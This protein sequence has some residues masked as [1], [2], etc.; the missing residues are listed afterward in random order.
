LDRRLT[1]I[2]A[3]D[4]VGYS[5]LMGE[6][7]TGTLAALRRF[8]T[9]LLARSLNS[10]SGNLIKSMGDG[11]LLGFASAADAAACALYLQH[12]LK[13]HETLKLRIGVHIG[14]VTFEEDDVYGDGINIAARL[15]EMV[16]P[17]A[18]L[19]SH[20]TMRLLDGVAGSDFAD[21]GRHRLKNIEKDMTIHVWPAKLSAELTPKAE[22][23]K[24]HKPRLFAPPFGFR[25]GADEELLA[26][27]ITGTFATQMGRMTGIELVMDAAEANYRLDGAVQAAGK[28]RRLIAHVIY[29]AEE[30]RLASEQYDVS[31]EDAFAIAEECAS[32]LYNDVRV[33][34]NHHDGYLASRKDLD[35]MTVEELLT[36][37][38]Y[39]TL[40]TDAKSWHDIRPL[41]D[42]VLAAE[43]DN[44][45]ALG[46]WSHSILADHLY[47]IKKT[48]EALQAEAWAKLDRA[49]H[50]NRLSAYV[51]LV[52]SNLT[53][54]FKNDVDEALYAAERSIEINPKFAFGYAAW[55]DALVAA[56]HYREGIEKVQLAFDM[57]PQGGYIHLRYHGL[58][59]GWFGLGDYAEAAKQMQNADRTVPNVPLFVLSSISSLWHSGDTDKARALSSELIAACPNIQLRDLHL[60]YWHDEEVAARYISGMLNA[61]I[62]E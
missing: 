49:Q 62:P 50:L 28:R 12:A 24:G 55:G 56:G 33:A 46:Q 54:T 21:A 60:N 34:I 3:A 8:R 42:L 43:P 53:L 39:K 26:E 45:T 16:P 37:G 61:G 19:I 51:H 15:Q 35:S 17:G 52:R 18:V 7:E 1:A 47:G 44:V 2:L 27:E 32:R 31:G 40:Q 25:G 11:W 5:R 29:Q 38:M 14:D 57:N 59:L 4:V 48:D 10:H 41:M 23:A 58:G 36:L 22:T 9:E 6:D 20:D 30:K 13:D